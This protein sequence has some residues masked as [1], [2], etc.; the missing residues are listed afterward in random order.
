MTGALEALHLHVVARDVIDDR[1]VAFLHLDRV[2]RVGDHLIAHSHLHA[3]RRAYVR[4]AMVRPLLEARR[5]IHRCLV[6][7][8]G[9]FCVSCLMSKQRTRGVANS[10]AGHP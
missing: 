10:S 2:A 1:V 5:W 8:G 4:Y 6:S 3:P 9:G 7:T